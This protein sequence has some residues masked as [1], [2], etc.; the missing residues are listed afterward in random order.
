[1]S[2]LASYQPNSVVFNDQNQQVIGTILRSTFKHNIAGS[3]SL[4]ENRYP[5][6]VAGYYQRIEQLL[7]SLISW[8]ASWYTVSM[9]LTYKVG[10]NGMSLNNVTDDCR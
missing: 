3:G 4:L 5:D 2:I 8:I 10:S 1:M 9:G 7:K 6:S